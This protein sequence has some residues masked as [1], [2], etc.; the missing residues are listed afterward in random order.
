MV[1]RV[2][3]PFSYSAAVA[4]GDYVFIGLHRGFGESFTQQIHD[5]FTNL[6]KTLQQCD[7]LLDQV[8]KMNVYLKNI[9]DLPYDDRWSSV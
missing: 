9:A 2:K 7:T 6:T 3:T 4:A 1:R 5:T 8:V